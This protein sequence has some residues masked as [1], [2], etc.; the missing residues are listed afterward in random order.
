MTFT[1]YSNKKWDY[2]QCN[3]WGGYF[4]SKWE[5]YFSILIWRVVDSLFICLFIY[6][7]YLFELYTEAAHLTYMTLG[8]FQN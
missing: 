3:G 8:S 4:I 5:Q 2:S 6:L 7:I 1:N